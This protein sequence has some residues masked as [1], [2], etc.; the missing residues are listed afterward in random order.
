MPSWLMMKLLPRSTSDVYFPK[1]AVGLSEPKVNK[2]QIEVAATP[3]RQTMPKENGTRKERRDTHSISATQLKITIVCGRAAI[4]MLVKTP[5]MSHRSFAAL[6]AKPQM[7]MTVRV[8]G[9]MPL[10]PTLHT[11]V[12]KPRTTEARTASRLDTRSRRAKYASTSATADMN[13]AVS[14]PSPSV[15]S[16]ELA[17]QYAGT[18]AAT[19]PAGLAITSSPVLNSRTQMSLSGLSSS[20]G[21]G[22]PPMTG[23]PVVPSSRDPN[24]AAQGVC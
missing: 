1:A 16:A 9:H 3:A 19:T 5:A 4:Q 17:S 7:P 23:E 6:H 18:A 8:C 13:A 10:A 24:W 21:M 22:S 2:F 12:V 11:G 20:G 14:A 15:K